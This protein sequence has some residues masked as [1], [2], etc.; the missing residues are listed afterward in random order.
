MSKASTL[1]EIER[2]RREYVKMS[3]EASKLSKSMEE[4]LDLLDL[5]LEDLYWTLSKIEDAI[6]VCKR[7]GWGVPPEFEEVKKDIEQMIRELK[8]EIEEVRGSTL[9]LVEAKMSVALAMLICL[10]H[11]LAFEKVKNKKGFMKIMT[12]LEER[13]RIGKYF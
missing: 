1:E 13:E 6:E 5:G 11:K 9:S 10:E 2:L 4:E 7:Y 3:K 12:Y 8:V